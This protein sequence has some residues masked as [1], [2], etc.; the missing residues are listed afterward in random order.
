M[1]LLL[2]IIGN[3][4]LGLIFKDEYSKYNDQWIE[5]GKPLNMFWRP[6][7]TFLSFSSLW[8]FGKC[9]IKWLF[10]CPNWIQNNK[11]ILIKLWIYRIITPLG[12]I[13]IVV[14]LIIGKNI[15]K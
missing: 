13:M 4:I 8:A 7:Q 11:Q 12:F 2:I 15:F 6:P 5:D 9:Q 1:G 14:S 3:Y 10:S